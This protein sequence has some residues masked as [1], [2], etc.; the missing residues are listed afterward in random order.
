MAGQVWTMINFPREI[1]DWQASAV[2]KFQCQQ[3]L[4][5]ILE[6]PVAAIVVAGVVVVVVAAAAAATTIIGRLEFAPRRAGPWRGS[7]WTSSE[8]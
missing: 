6:L 2:Q 1:G 5:N 8:R 3:L 7:P 4:S